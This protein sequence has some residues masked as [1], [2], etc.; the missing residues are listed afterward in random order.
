MDLNVFIYADDEN[1]EK[2]RKSAFILHFY[3][4]IWKFINN[5]SNGESFYEFR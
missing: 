1:I 2:Y 3:G 4:Y 5:K